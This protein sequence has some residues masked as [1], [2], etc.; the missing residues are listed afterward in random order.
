MCQRG[1]REAPPE[2]LGKVILVMS[3][4][5]RKMY[6]NLEP[7]PEGAILPKR[8]MPQEVTRSPHDT[9][10]SMANWLKTNIQGGK[11]ALTPSP[12]NR[13]C[14]FQRIRLKH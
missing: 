9:G 4:Q 2:T 13:T 6:Q 1:E 12:Q 7:K 11:V 3:G 14:T 8:S 10:A 5:S